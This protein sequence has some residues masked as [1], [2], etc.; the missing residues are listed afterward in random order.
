MRMIGVPLDEHGR[1]DHAAIDRLLER[2][3][4]DSARELMAL[5]RERPGVL[6]MAE[7]NPPLYMDVSSAY[8]GDELGLPNRDFIGEGIVGAGDLVVSAGAGNSVNVAAGACWVIG[9]TNPLAQPTYRM[10]NDAVRNLGITPDPALARRVRI[11][12]QITDQ[13]FSGAS[14]SWALQALLGTPNASPVLPAEPASA[15]SL[16]NILVPAAAASSAAYTITDLR[17][18]ATVGGGQAAP[19]ASLV[20]HSVRGKQSAAQSLPSAVAGG[21]AIV[22]DAEDWDSDGYH[23]TVTNNTRLTIPAGLGGLYFL[24]G[25]LALANPSAAT[26]VTAMI[27]KNGT[28]YLAG[29]GPTDNYGPSNQVWG[30]VG[31]VDLAVP[32]D[33]YELMGLNTE[34]TQN[35]I[36][37][38]A[39]FSATYLVP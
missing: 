1:V 35:I 34:A 39:F 11:V 16:A 10:T 12:A 24:T 23:D 22:F 30:S 31:F 20:R 18:R 4:L 29:G 6:N 5:A 14:R 7:V 17:A 38:S 36:A 27:R 8:S 9:D 32:G 26:R 28:T 37:A 33:Y 19:A 21:T 15:I 25:G 13:T 2:R 3:G